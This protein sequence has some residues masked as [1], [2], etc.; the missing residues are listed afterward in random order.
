MT[1]RITVLLAMMASIAIVVAVSA[2][3][4]TRRVQD[5]TR[6]GLNSGNYGNY[7]E[8]Y[9]L[10]YTGGEFSYTDY[11]EWTSDQ[12]YYARRKDVYLSI[13]YQHLVTPYGYWDTPIFSVDAYRTSSMKNYNGVGAVFWLAQWAAGSCA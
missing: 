11:S 7:E 6:C 12:P 9:V 2:Q 5:Q 4:S 3:G 8:R 13:T 1:K 10:I